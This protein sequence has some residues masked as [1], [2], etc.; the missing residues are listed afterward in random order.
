MRR[1]SRPKVAR[2]AWDN[3]TNRLAVGIVVSM[4]VV[5][6]VAGWAI[7]RS[8][9][10]SLMT[11]A[12]RELA[13]TIG[14]Q[15]RALFN[16]GQVPDPRGAPPDQP[17]SLP[18]DAPRPGGGQGG[19]QGGPGQ[20]GGP[21]P[22]QGEDIAPEDLELPQTVN[23]RF[24]IAL[25]DNDGNLAQFV[26]SGVG[27]DEDPVPSVEEFRRV[28]VG[29]PGSGAPDTIVITSA[30][31]SLN[32]IAG[33]LP[34]PP[35]VGGALIQAAPLD[36]VDASLADLRHTLL[37]VGALGFLALL[38]GALFVLRQGLR[39]VRRLEAAA[40]KVGRGELE[41]RV[42][43]VS[44]APDMQRV[45]W[46]FDA[47]AENTQATI[48]LQQAIQTRLRRFVADAS[49]ELRTPL[50]ALRGHAELFRMGAL[51]DPELL[52]QSLGRI[53]AQAM[54]MGSLVDDLL[55][56]AEV[57]QPSERESVPVDVSALVADAMADLRAVDPDRPTSLDAVPAAIVHGDEERL[58]RIVENLVSNAR[59]HTA[60]D[61]WVGARVSLANGM[62][63]LEVSDHG[64]GIPAAH[65]GRVFDRFWRADTSRARSEGSSGLGLAIVKQ[66]VEDHRGTITVESTVGQGTTFRAT[67]PTV[68]GDSSESSWVQERAESAVN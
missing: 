17:G 22:F 33:A 39:P 37:L 41:A 6:A 2:P 48:E 58:R 14:P 23:N 7:L 51:E 15:M 55:V 61:A 45:A 13:G 47:M 42:G 38:F 11:R 24:L 20:P 1:P 32:Y 36:D 64:A 65:L 43:P 4:L 5:G 54:R 49:H 34:M 46:T 18:P 19:G 50:T 26:P 16:S 28:P 12:S 8:A 3:L 10:D 67:L 27:G 53:E 9:E 56:M 68:G 44:G 21:P 62:V 40:E 31:G 59:K 30:D 60:P 66:V 63:E 25:L 52:K 29:A 57:D 35:N